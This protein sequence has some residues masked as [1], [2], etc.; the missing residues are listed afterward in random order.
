MI[1]PLQEAE[2]EVALGAADRLMYRAKRT[3]PNAPIV[4]TLG[5]A[6]AA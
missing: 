2:L 5:D 3:S 1:D 4:R 6:L